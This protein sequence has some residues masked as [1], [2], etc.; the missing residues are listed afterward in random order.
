MTEECEESLSK[1]KDSL[2]NCVV[3]SHPDFSQP[4]ILSIDASLDGLG[5]VLSQVPAGEKKTRPIA[6]ASKTLS[7]SQKKYPAHKLEFLALKWSVCEK[8]SHWLKGHWFT[9]WTD[10]NPLTYIMT[11]PKLDTCEQHWVSKLAPYTF[12]LKHIPGTKNIVADTLSRDPFAK[13]VSQRLINE[14]YEQLL[15]EAEGV[16]PDSIQD[17]FRLKVQCHQV[18]TKQKGMTP[19]FCST[20][21]CCSTDVSALLDVNSEWEVATDT[22]AVQFIQAVQDTLSV[23]TLAE[24][25]RS[26]ENDPTI[27]VLMPFVSRKNGHLNGKEQHLTQKL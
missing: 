22:R 13:T 27:S 23:F 9:V 21:G 4:L 12:D 8:F 10:N 2:L 25:Q 1:L 19:P 18:K 26:Q 15:T 7:V 6:F 20:K 17:T 5:A 24:L 3:L 11:K 16:N 14:Q